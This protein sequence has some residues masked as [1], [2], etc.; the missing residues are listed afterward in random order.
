MSATNPHL[1]GCLIVQVTWHFDNNPE[2]VRKRVYMLPED[3]RQLRLL[4]SVPK[5]GRLGYFSTSLTTL[6][7]DNILMVQSVGY[8]KANA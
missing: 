4:L 5:G 8:Y 1:A 7:L 6:S 2:P 3:Y